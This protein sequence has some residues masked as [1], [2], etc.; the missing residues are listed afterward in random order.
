MKKKMMVMMCLLAIHLSAK[1]ADDKPIKF[2][3]LPTRAQQWISQHFAGQSVALVKMEDDFFEKSYEVIFT[4]GNKIE[5]N[6]KGDWMEIDC[7]YTQL[8]EQFIPVAI[9]DYVAQHYPGV[10]INKIEK[11]SRKG[12]EIELSN[13]IGLKFDSAFRVIE[14][15]N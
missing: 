1:A 6:R 2:E 10:K 3:Q 7:K 11:E 4:N 14:M 13:G 8:P 12:H 9:K 5:L 15:D